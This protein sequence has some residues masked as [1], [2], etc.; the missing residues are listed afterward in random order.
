MSWARNCNFTARLSALIHLTSSSKFTFGALLDGLLFEEEDAF[1]WIGF[2]F[3]V[4]EVNLL[5]E[6][7]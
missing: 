7:Q 6:A 4:Y 1:L 3:V 5:G 2:R